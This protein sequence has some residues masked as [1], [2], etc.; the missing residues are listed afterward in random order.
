MFLITTPCIRNSLLGQVFRKIHDKWLNK[1]K[2]QEATPTKVPVEDVDTPVAFAPQDIPATQANFDS[3][4]S[5]LQDTVSLSVLEGLEFSSPLDT[6]IDA[7]T[8]SASSPTLSVSTISNLTPTESGEDVLEGGGEP[9][10][11]RHETFYLEDGNIE[12]L[13]G[14]TIFRIHSPIVSFSSPKLRD[15]LS[16]STILTTPPPEDCPRIIF[17]DSAEDFAVLLKMI[18]TPG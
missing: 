9:M 2:Q 12:I 10:P 8:S 18:Y 14:H 7:R 4:S 17:N 6:L 11:T 3:P 16:Q 5:A 1:A 13:C 15:L